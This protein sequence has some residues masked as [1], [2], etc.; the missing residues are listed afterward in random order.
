MIKCGQCWKCFPTT[1]EFYDPKLHNQCVQGVFRK[2]GW[3]IKGEEV[4]SC[5]K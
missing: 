1:A 4:N 2:F 5:R 3:I